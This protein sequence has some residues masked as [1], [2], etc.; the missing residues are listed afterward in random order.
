MGHRSLLLVVGGNSRAS[1][2]SLIGREWGGQIIAHGEQAQGRRED[3]RSCQ[4]DCQ[5]WE[6]ITTE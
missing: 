6:P 1:E 2:C 4:D 3:V 5:T